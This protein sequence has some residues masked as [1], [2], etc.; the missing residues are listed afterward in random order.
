LHLLRHLGPVTDRVG[1]YPRGR[2]A[3]VNQDPHRV[4]CTCWIHHHGFYAH[5]QLTTE[6]LLEAERVWIEAPNRRPQPHP[7][8]IELMQR[9]SL[10]C[11]W[12]GKRWEPPPLL[13]RMRGD[14]ERELREGSSG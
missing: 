12:T 6:E 10:G 9:E 5:Y 3:F 4:F 2:P 11:E 7:R 8:D 14:R 1:A 13:T